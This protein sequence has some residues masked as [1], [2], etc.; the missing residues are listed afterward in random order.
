MEVFHNTPF[1][2]S[3]DA[4]LDKDGSE[5]RVIVLKATYEIKKNSQL[6]IAEEQEPICEGDQFLGKPSLS[7]TLYEDDTAAFFKPAT[8]II[9]VGHAYAPQD[10]PVKALHCSLTVGTKT[11]TIAVFGN[12]YW[13]YS[14]LFG[15]VKTDP[16][17]FFKIPLYWERAF[18]GK[19]TYHDDPSKHSWD[20]YNPIGT[21]FRI[22]KT[23]ESLEGLALPNF[24]DPRQ[25]IKSWKDKP[26][27]QGFGFIGRHWL[28]RRQYAGTYD[29][30]W[31]KY[32]M[33]IL[34]VD[35]D[36]R[37]FNGAT[38]DLIYPGHLKGGEPVQAINLSKEPLP[39]F[40]LPVCRVIFRAVAKRKPIEQEGILDTVVFKFDENKVILVWRSKYAVTI[41]EAADEAEAEVIFLS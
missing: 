6:T 10:Q 25:L 17:P 8:D 15:V 9:V 22:H 39:V 28:P 24:E 32:R 13:D 3:L 16:E 38:P 12:R 41:R 18:G 37:F 2:T 4:I 7:S 40:Q 20:E 23:A 21:G 35:F 1:T 36:D 19:D 14:K 33:P 11:K 34:P 29:E 31:Q 27:P 30:A 5:A 26:K